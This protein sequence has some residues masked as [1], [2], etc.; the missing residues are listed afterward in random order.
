MTPTATADRFYMGLALELAAR[1][2]GRTSPNPLVGAV[3]AKDGRIIGR[4]FHVR[5]GEPHAEVLALEEAGAA[6]RGAD[7]Y[8]TLEPCSHHGRTPPCAERVVAS[9]VRRTVVAM[10]DPNPL[11]GGRGVAALRAAG[12]EVVAGVRE[13]EARRLNEAFC[14]SIRERRAFA[15]LK[16]AA[17]LDGRIATRSGDSRW[18]SSVESRERVHELRDRCQAVVVGVGTVVADDPRLTVRR[19][20]RPERRILRV[21]VDPRLRVPHDRLLLQADEASHTLVACGPGVPVRAEEQL[22]RTGAGLLR[23]PETPSGGLDLGALLK[24]LYGR[25]MM[26]ALVE[27]GAATARAFLDQGLVDRVHWF[28][29]P[30]ILGGVD[31]LGAVGGLSPERMNEAWELLDLEVERVGPDLYLTGRPAGRA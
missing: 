26:E 30:R 25:G 16:L 5:A 18:V 8:V 19:P 31:A 27:G 29:S 22:R 17:T 28:V 23:L 14:L 7:L 15:H 4:G 3:V 2:V 13:T 1:A 24:E 6:A 21:V 11:V 20:G 9:G 10:E 12:V